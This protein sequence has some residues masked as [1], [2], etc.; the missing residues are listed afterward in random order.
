MAGFKPVSQEEQLAMIRSGQNP[1]PQGGW[2]EKQEAETVCPK[3]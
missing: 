1:M 3:L 2:L